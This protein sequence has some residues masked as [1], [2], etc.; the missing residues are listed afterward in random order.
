MILGVQKWAGSEV[1]NPFG[2]C[3]KPD[4]LRQA[5]PSTSCQHVWGILDGTHSPGGWEQWSW[6]VGGAGS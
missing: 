6:M 1:Q 3:S 2:H 4:S 5:A